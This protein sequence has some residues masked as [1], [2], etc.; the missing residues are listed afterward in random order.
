MQGLH[1]NYGLFR[2]PE[3]A[4]VR[5]PHLILSPFLGTPRKV[6]IMSQI[7]LFVCPR[8]GRGEVATSGFVSFDMFPKNPG[9]TGKGVELY[10]AVCPLPKRL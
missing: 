1:R 9:A 8:E 3:K 7:H 10:G 6:G 2:T 5:Q 4:R